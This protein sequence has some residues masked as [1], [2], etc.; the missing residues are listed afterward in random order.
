[1]ADLGNQMLQLD[2]ARVDQWDLEAMDVQVR[3]P[4]ACKRAGSTIVIG[5]NM[6]DDQAAQTLRAEVCERKTD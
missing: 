5:M 4:I 6:C 3:K 2:V 1:M